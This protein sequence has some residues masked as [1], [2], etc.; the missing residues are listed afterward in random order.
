MGTTKRT[1]VKGIIEDAVYEHMRDEKYAQMLSGAM[2]KMVS[3]FFAQWEIDMVFQNHW[4]RR[5]DMVDAD[6][7]ARIHEALWNKRICSECSD[8]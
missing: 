3:G 8:K 1:G 2:Q 5:L 7:F 4:S 6:C